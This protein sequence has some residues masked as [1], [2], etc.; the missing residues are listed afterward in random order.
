MGGPEPNDVT[1]RRRGANR[2]HR[3]GPNPEHAK[4]R[5]D[6]RP[7]PATRT[8]WG[9]V[10]GIGVLGLAAEVADGGAGPGKFVEVGFGEDDPT[11]VAYLGDD[12]GVGVGLLVFEDGGAAGRRHAVGEDV[13]FDDDGDAVQWAD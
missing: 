1:G 10:E 7:G 2:V 13:V 9:V 4:V 3:V 12:V 5:R 8:T 11:R 6:G